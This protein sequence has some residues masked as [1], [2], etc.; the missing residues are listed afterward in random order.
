MQVTI[1]GTGSGGPFQGRHYSAQVVHVDQHLFLVDR[2]E[3]TQMQLFRTKIKYDRFGQIFISHLHGDHVYGLAGLL[4][5]YALKQRSEPLTLFGP[6]GLQD[7]I[8]DQIRHSLTRIPYPLHFVTVDTTVHQMVFENKDVEVWSIPLNHRVPCNGGLFREK[9][10]QRN[11]IKEKIE[12]Y[13]IPWEAIPAIKAGADYR[14]PDGR[15]VPNNELTTPPRKPLIYAFCS[16]T[17][18]SMDVVHAVKQVDLLY[19]E[20]TFSNEHTSEAEIT[21][22]S[23]AAQAAE[24]AREAEVGALVLGH[25]SARYKDTGVLLAEA[26]AVF[27]NT[28]LCEDGMVLQVGGTNPA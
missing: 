14:H 21:G 6:A 2:G 25:F 7:L 3:G 20:A 19:H 1:L 5:S 10:Q 12:T 16:D 15:I 28:F 4:T 8:G 11:M 18:P 26:Q 27:P 22:H 17:S 24:V 9:V 13:G 23:T